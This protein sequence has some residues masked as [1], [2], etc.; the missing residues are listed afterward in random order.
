MALGEASSSRAALA[1]RSRPE[2]SKLERLVLVGVGVGVVVGVFRG[3]RPPNMFGCCLKIGFGFG[4]L[5][6]GCDVFLLCWNVS[7]DHGCFG[8]GLLNWLSL[9]LFLSTQA[10]VLSS[11][12]ASR[13]VQC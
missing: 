10:Q 2:G 4:F 6:R 9:S 11:N 5:K 3:L 8:S 7:V 13:G 1:A 12:V